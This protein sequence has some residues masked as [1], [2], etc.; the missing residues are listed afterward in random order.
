MY[1]EATAVCN[2]RLEPSLMMPPKVIGTKGSMLG[3]T[4]IAG[5]S[6]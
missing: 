6:T 2:D 3:F 4:A 5:W 1:W